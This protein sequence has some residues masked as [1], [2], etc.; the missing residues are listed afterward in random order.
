MTHRVALETIS[1]QDMESTSGK[2]TVELLNSTLSRLRV[3]SPSYDPF[4]RLFTGPGT[5]GKSLIC[6]WC[7]LLHYEGDLAF[8]WKQLRLATRIFD[9]SGCYSYLD[10]DLRELAKRAPKWEQYL[11]LALLHLTRIR[12]RKQLRRQL[13][14]QRN[15]LTRVFPTEIVEKVVAMVV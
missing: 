15:D 3:R 6:H 8:H 4:F 9:V 10:D 13:R 1:T 7:H 11:H 5:S 14:T 2:N 12:E